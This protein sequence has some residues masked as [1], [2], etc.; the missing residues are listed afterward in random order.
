MGSILTMAMKDLRL[1]SRD[2]LGMFFIIGFPIAMGLFFGSFLG[3]PDT[4]TARLSIAV[5]DQDES[6]TSKKFIDELKATGNFEIES[7][8]RESATDRVRSGKLV[9]MVVIPKKYGETAGMPWM[10]SPAI[11]IGIDPSRSAEASMLEGLIMQVSGKLMMNRFRDPASLKPMLAKARQDIES[12]TDMPTALRPILAQMMTTLDS[13]SQT[14]AD[15]KAAEETSGDKSKNGSPGFQIA[16]IERVDVTREIRK[17]STEELFSQMR[18][19]WDISFPQASMWGVLA[20][21]AGFAITIV[22][23]RKQGTLLRLQVAPVTRAQ[24][25]GG[26]A[27]ACFLAVVGVIVIMLALGIWLGMRPRS[28][29][30]L[31]LTAVSIAFCFVGIMMLMSVIGKTEESVSGAAW[32]ANMLMAMFGGAMVPLMFM[33]PFFKAVSNF[34]P[35]KWSILALEGSIW[36]GFM[37]AEL[38]TPC[39]ILVAI[40]AVCFAIGARVL[41]R[42]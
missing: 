29:G 20:C 10:E 3:P 5:V 12:S 22:R 34:S 17:G 14:M 19:R 26:K 23:E 38:A 13:L 39:C 41:S 1:M 33:P 2:W 35:V 42:D 6:P 16:R 11:E 21:A 8:G 24:V 40:G 7:L 31:T 30:L 28:F 36:R 25:L 4:K 15:V 27:L 9:G 32:G 37:L 18:S